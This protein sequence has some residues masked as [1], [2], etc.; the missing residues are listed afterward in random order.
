MIG[1]REDA[2]HALINMWLKDTTKRCGWC[3]SVY[4]PLTYPCCEKPFI[5]TNFEIMRQ[6]YKELKEDRKTRKNEFAST[7]KKTLRWKLS[8]PPSL[9]SFLTHSFQKLYNEK[10]FHDKYNTT[11]F[12]R[13]FKKAFT[14]AERI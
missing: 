5:A 12:A 10:L 1:T 3:S 4:N 2:I 7:G 13:R 9:L 8:F 14:V 11:W 6:F